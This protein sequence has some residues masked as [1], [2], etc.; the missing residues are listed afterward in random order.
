LFGPFGFAISGL[1]KE[2]GVKNQQLKWFFSI[3]R[4]FCHSERSEESKALIIKGFRFF[5]ALRM[6][7][8]FHS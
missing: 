3:F 2:L 4:E 5:A 8:K 7:K 6:T 1:F